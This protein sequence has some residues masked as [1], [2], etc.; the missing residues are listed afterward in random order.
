MHPRTEGDGFLDRQAR[1]E[2]SVAILEHHL[3]AAAKFAQ[4]QRRAD[5]HA[6][7]D[8]VAGIARHQV[9]QEP[10][11]GRLA[12]TGFADDADGLA[13][14]HRKGD[15]VDRAHGLAR[16]E[17]IAA[18]G[19]VFC[20]AL[21]LEQRLRRAAAVLDRLKHVCGQGFAHALN[22][23]YPWRCAGRRSAD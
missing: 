19:E 1:V 14:H 21:D 4:A 20:Q 9:H 5:L 16:A 8:D 2:R 17:E 15:V 3:H 13:L 10:R 18:D 12:A 6:V 23:G 22:S 7:I 11:R